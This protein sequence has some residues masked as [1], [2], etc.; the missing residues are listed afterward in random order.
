[1]RETRG[2]LGGTAANDRLLPLRASSGTHTDAPSSSAEPLVNLV[3]LGIHCSAQAADSTSS[4]SPTRSQLSVPALCLSPTCHRTTPRPAP[5]ATLSQRWRRSFPPRPQPAPLPVLAC[6]RRRRPARWSPPPPWP[7]ALR[8]V[9]C[10]ARSRRRRSGQA[11]VMRPRRVLSAAAHCR[12]R[13]PTRK[14]TSCCRRSGLVSSAVS[15]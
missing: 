8:R 11:L 3:V 1:M 2:Q 14:C 9:R 4:P 7:A 10:S 13:R 15:S 5:S 6:A 12:W